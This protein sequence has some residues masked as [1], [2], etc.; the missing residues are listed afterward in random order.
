MKEISGALRCDTLTGMGKETDDLI[1]RGQR[2]IK[3]AEGTRKMHAKK[4]RRDSLGRI[5]DVKL[6]R[7]RI[8]EVMKDLR[9]VIH[10]NASVA[11]W[12]VTADE[13]KALRELSKDLQRQRMKLHR[14]IPLEAW[15]EENE[16]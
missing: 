2:A 9:P 1:R 5:Q 14:F 8:A 12:R 10:W 13:Y 3:L 4:S 15:K 6:A 7:Q 16:D 11:H